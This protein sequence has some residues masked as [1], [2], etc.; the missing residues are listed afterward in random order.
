[1][2]AVGRVRSKSYTQYKTE[3][4]RTWEQN[5]K[6]KTNDPQPDSPIKT[7]LTSTAAVAERWGVQRF[8]RAKIPPILAA[9]CRENIPTGKYNK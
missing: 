2:L 9:G 3:K 1:M 4:Q 7:S 6:I 8:D 5:M